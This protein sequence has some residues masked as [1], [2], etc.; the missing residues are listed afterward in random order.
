MTNNVENL[1]MCLLNIYVSCLEKYLFRSFAYFLIGVFVFLLL[2][3]KNSLHIIATHPL[4]DT[5]FAN[6][7]T[8]WL[9]C[10]FNF[11]IMTFEAKKFLTLMKSN[12][13]FVCLFVCFGC[14]VNC[15]VAQSC[16]TV[17]DPMD[18]SLLGSSVHGIFQA[19]ILEYV[20]ISFSRRSSWPR[21]WTRVSR[22]IGR[23]FTVWATREVLISYTPTKKL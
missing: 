21:Y 1:L 10:L 13:R 16:L 15:E 5:W 17:C 6:I 20:A 18:C 11:L 9:G 23:H 2:S 8:Q 14:Y 4:S 3:C 22:I 19:R 12:L 7:F